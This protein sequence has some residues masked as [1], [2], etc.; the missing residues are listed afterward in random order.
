MELFDLTGRVVEP[1]PVESWTKLRVH[2]LRLQQYLPLFPATIRFEKSWDEVETIDG[3]SNIICSLAS[4]R[5]IERPH[6]KFMVFL[7]FNFPSS[8]I[9]GLFSWL[10][11][12]CRLLDTCIRFPVQRITPLELVTFNKSE[13]FALDSFILRSKFNS[14]VSIEREYCR[15]YPEYPTRLNCRC[16]E[17]DV[18]SLYRKPSKYVVRRQSN[19]P[20]GQ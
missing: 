17:S 15:N 20:N 1:W 8:A 19:R 10:M 18:N 6:P 16:E 4:T 3:E 11:L 5:K 12:G 9:P 2:A 14:H 7:F 13:T